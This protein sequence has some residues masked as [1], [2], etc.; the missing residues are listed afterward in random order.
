[1]SPSTPSPAPFPS[2]LK[3]LSTSVE[4]EQLGDSWSRYWH[5]AAPTRHQP[6]NGESRESNTQAR[7]WA[8]HYASASTSIAVCMCRYRLGATHA[9]LPAQHYACPSLY[10]ALR[11]RC[12][13]HHTTHV[14][15][16]HRIA[17]ARASKKQYACTILGT[18][19]RTCL[20]RHSTTHAR[21]SARH[22]ASATLGITL[23]VCKSQD[24]I[25]HAP[26]SAPNRAFLSRE[27]ST[28]APAPG[29]QCASLAT[30]LRVR[31]R[32]RILSHAHFR[33]HTY[34][35]VVFDSLLCRRW[36]QGPLGARVVCSEAGSSVKPS[37]ETDKEHGRLRENYC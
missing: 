21:A 8:L 29:P 25:A 3:T 17:H 9:L 16:A 26:R 14:L 1:M 35:C 36:A 28:H 22:C 6:R 24:R 10:T 34:A 20:Y 37:K 7:I 2:R 4:R 11:K 31:Q 32:A 23:R 5:A 18:A 30:A 12:P 15:L 27:G 13:P 33:V 19:L